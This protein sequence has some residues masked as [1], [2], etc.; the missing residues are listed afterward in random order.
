MK[1]IVISSVLLSVVLMVSG[2]SDSKSNEIK[3]VKQS[4]VKNQELIDKKNTLISAVKSQ[5]VKTEKKI[6]DSKTDKERNKYLNYL[7][8][9]KKT[10]KKYEAD[11]SKLK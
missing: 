3:V 6:Q 9:Y 4:K 5:I 7:S 10:L 11:L 2:C 8:I 1:K